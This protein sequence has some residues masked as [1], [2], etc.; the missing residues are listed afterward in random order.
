M[1]SLERKE[2]S[3]REI[4]ERQLVLEK[5]MLRVAKYNA[6]GSIH[7]TFQQA[8]LLVAITIQ[9]AVN[10]QQGLLLQA[11]VVTFEK[12]GF[13][14]SINI[15][16]GEERIISAKST[17]LASFYFKSIDREITYDGIVPKFEI[18][19]TYDGILSRLTK[20]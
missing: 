2:Y 7:K 17:A 10:K 5:R 8:N 11:S 9:A 19:K 13:M 3:M 4:V 14:H 6:N 12:G 1:N 15:P 16:T 20:E 18:P